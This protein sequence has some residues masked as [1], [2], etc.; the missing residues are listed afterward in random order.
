MRFQGNKNTVF[1][2]VF[3]LFVSFNR[4]TIPAHGKGLIY[5][6]IKIITISNIL[7]FYSITYFLIFKLY[8]LIF[9]FQFLFLRQK[10]IGL[11]LCH[12]SHIFFIYLYSCLYFVHINCIIV[13][14][15]AG[16]GHP[17]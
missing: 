7:K 14:I 3:Y 16:S 15:I 12:A 17:T 13:N 6:C 11:F 2:Y 10:F 5:S 9:I 4:A 8:S 1:F